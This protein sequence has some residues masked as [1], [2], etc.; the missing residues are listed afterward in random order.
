MRL[1][2]STLLLLL[3]SIFITAFSLVYKSFSISKTYFV[4]T[5]FIFLFGLV[6]TLLLDY[7]FFG[8]RALFPH[9]ISRFTRRWKGYVWMIHIILIYFLIILVYLI[10]RQGIFSKISGIDLFRSLMLGSN[11]YL[12]FLT[13][14]VFF[15]S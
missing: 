5:A 2:T 3:L 10:I 6:T 14:Y 1:N 13:L 9:Y 12:W 11:I 8:I 4:F 15:K 7:A